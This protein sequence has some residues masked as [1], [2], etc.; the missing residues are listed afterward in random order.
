MC[1]SL[2]NKRQ[3]GQ[4]NLCSLSHPHNHGTASYKLALK[5]RVQAQSSWL[6]IQRSGFDSQHY[7][8][9]LVVGLEGVALRLLSTIEELLERRNSGF[10]LENREYGRRVRHADHVAP[11][12]RKKLA[13]T[14]PTSG[15][16]S[17]GI[18]RSWTQATEFFWSARFYFSMQILIRFRCLLFYYLKFMI[19]TE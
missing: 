13:L 14:S 15:C 5:C 7:Q 9:F 11:C 4:T 10:G 19:I 6:Q 2:E 12:I 17:V 16:R 8:I 1:F 3:G 18:V